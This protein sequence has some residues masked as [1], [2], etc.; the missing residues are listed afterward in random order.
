MQGNALEKN[1][2]D[3]DDYRVEMM[4]RWDD[5]DPETDWYKKRRPLVTAAEQQIHEPQLSQ[6]KKATRDIEVFDYSD[7]LFRRLD[8]DALV[9]MYLILALIQQQAT[10]QGTNINRVQFLNL[11]ENQIFLP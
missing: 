3:W 6:Y 5:N 10:E 2:K 7:Y 8:P 1:V 11:P 4:T 9:K